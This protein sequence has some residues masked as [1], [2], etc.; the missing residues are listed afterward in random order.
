[1]RA[2]PEV[3]LSEELLA[4]TSQIGKMRK[5]LYDLWRRH[6]SEGMLPTS[7]RFLFYELVTAGVISKVTKTRSDGKKGR[8]P[9]QDMIEAL[10]DL[11]NAGIIP[12]TDIVDETR[13]LTEWAVY[14]SITNAMRESWKNARLN[15]WESDRA[16]IN[17]RSPARTGRPLASCT[18][19]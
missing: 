6:Q 16:P 3:K 12:W 13:D 11:R 18:R 19:P 5:A 7:A 17:L 1:L 14:D 4:T 15:L 10:T 2:S 9:D 8:R